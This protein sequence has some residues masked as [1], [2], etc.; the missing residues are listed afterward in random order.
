LGN[1]H[2]SSI[3]DIWEDST[4]IEEVRSLTAEA[5]KFY[6]KQSAELPLVRFCVGCALLSTGN[7]LQTYPAIEKSSRIWNEV[8][9]EKD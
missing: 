7:P 6:D 4:A 5:K 3:K 1:L 2:Q 9:K 8:Q